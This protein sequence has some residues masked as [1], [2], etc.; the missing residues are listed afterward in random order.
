MKKERLKTA[1]MRTVSSANWL[2]RQINDPYV[3]KAKKDGYRS[4]AAY[5][6]IEIDEKFKIFKKG[7]R[8][9]DLGAAPGGWSQIVVKKVG[10]NEENPMVLALDILPMRA[11]FGVKIMTMDFLLDG[12][13][14]AIISN[15]NGKA[16][17]VL[18]DMAANTTGNPK[19]DH[20]KIMNLLE[21]AYDFAKK[22]L[23]ENGVFV[24]KIFQGGTETA[25]LEA[26]K[27]DFTSVKHFKPK[28]SRQ[29]SREYYV[30]AKGFRCKES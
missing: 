29:E 30:V 20:M 2:R 27:R 23:S 8:V 25:L 21:L 7:M 19:L 18:S 26:I 17:V 24:A 5:K 1:K 9:V 22:V 16:D 15:L 12:A 14:E 11:M 6:I 4:R 13:E 28:S 10:E 3:L